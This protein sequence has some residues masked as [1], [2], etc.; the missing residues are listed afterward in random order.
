MFSILTG[1]GPDSGNPGGFDMT[2]EA[3]DYGIRKPVQRKSRLNARVGSFGAWP[4]LPMAS[5]W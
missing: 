1:I 2:V 5:S 4:G 3:L